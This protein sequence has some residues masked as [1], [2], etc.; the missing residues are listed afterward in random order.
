MTLYSQCPTQNQRQISFKNSTM[1]T[2]ACLSLS[3]LNLTALFRFPVQFWQD[4][5]VLLRQKSTENQPTQKSYFIFKATS[6]GDTRKAWS[7]RWSNPAYRLS[8]TKERFAKRCNKLRTMF[9]KLRYPKTLVNSSINKVSQEPDKYTRCIQQTHGG[10]ISSI[11][12]KQHMTET[13]KRSRQDSKTRQ[14]HSEPKDNQK[15]DD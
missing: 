6:T 8:S 4:V 1:C 11:K 10:E 9:S 2:L 14:K 15:P 5:L 7:T 13:Q 3:N 12:T